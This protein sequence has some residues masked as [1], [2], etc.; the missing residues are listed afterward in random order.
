MSLTKCTGLETNVPSILGLFHILA[1]MVMEIEME[2]AKKNLYALRITFYHTVRSS[3]STIVVK[4]CNG[5]VVILDVR[6][7]E[8]ASTI[9]GDFVSTVIV[10][11]AAH[12]AEIFPLL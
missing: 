11:S 3:Y 12:V 9:T 7:L 1:K 5:D 8:A 2:M 4:V 6:H 10:M